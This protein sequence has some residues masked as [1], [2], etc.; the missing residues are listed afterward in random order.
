M[1][2]L[3]IAGLLSGQVAATAPP[4]TPPAEP[5][6]PV[7]AVLPTAEQRERAYPR[8]AR[9][10]QIAGGALVRCRAEANG[11]LTQCVIVDEEPR[12]W[13]FGEAALRLASTARVRD[14]TSAGGPVEGRSVPMQ[15]AFGN[16]RMSRLGSLQPNGQL[17]R[18]PDW[19]VAPSGEI[20]ARALQSVGIREAPD[21]VRVR[22]RC[23]VAIDGT[24]Q[25]CTVL[26]SEAAD[27]RFGQAA[28][29]VSRELRFHP[30][31]VDGRSTGDG[32]VTIPVHL[33]FQTRR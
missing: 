24:L 10:Q 8:R 33:Q 29:A 11:T 20:V 13:S 14:T 6:H 19:A 15:V 31:T 28:L 9:L 22:L 2:E 1:I 27:P 3:V 26:S 25:E 18:A 5:D 23:R 4:V 16:F 32:V 7:W 30:Q 21:L 12:G 17:I